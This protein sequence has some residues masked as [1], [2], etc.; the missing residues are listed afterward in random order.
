MFERLTDRARKVMAGLFRAFWVAPLNL[1]SYV[2]L[3]ARDELGFPYIR[4]LPMAAVAREVR[5]RYHASSGFLRLV[6]DHLAGMTDRYALEE[7]RS[8]EQP[9]LDQRFSGE[10]E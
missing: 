7:H 6:V 10:L 4:D 9:A 3:R 1:P 5:D 8:L 2:L